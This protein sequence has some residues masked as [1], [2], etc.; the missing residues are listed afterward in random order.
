MEL[1]GFLVLFGMLIFVVLASGTKPSNAKGYR[2]KPERPS[3]W[4]AKK[5]KR[6]GMADPARQLE[7]VSCVKFQRSKIM[8]LSE[9]RVFQALELIVEESGADFRVMAQ[10]SLG[11][12][13]RPVSEAGDWKSRK[14]AFASINSKRLDFAV[15]DKQ[16]Y[17]ALA[18]EYQGSGHHQG[19]AFIRDAVK[20]EALRRAGIAFI[21][22]EKGCKPSEFR[23]RVE[24]ALGLAATSEPGLR[25]AG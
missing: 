22:V 3:A 19:A 1:L 24:N 2:S 7:A 25:D 21:E 17:V 10:V 13:I 5:E 15:I 11:E 14:D 12:V 18:I 23:M 6:W 9:Y 4:P 16:G 8:N 20:K